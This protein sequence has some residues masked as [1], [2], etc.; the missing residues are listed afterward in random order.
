MSI[1]KTKTPSMNQKIL[2]IIPIIAIL[3]ILVIVLLPQTTD[4]VSAQLVIDYGT[5][6]IQHNNGAWE[7]ATSG[8][9]L[10]QSDTI[11]T[12]ENTYASIILFESSII[13]LDSNTQVFIKELIQ[14]A[15]ATNVTIEQETGRTW[16]TIQKI[17]GID[18]YEVQTPTT[19]ASV[20]GTTFDVNVTGQG[21][22]NVSVIRGNVNVS[23][24]ENGTIIISIP[25]KGNESIVVDP[26]SSKPLKKD[27]VTK[28]EWIRRNLGEDD[29]LYQQ[30]KSEL[31]D[32]LEEYIPDLKDRYGMS[33]EELEILIDG[34]LQGEIDLPPDT[35][36]WIRD[37]I[38]NP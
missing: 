20:R 1:K 28:D 23:K 10:Y 34:Y 25:V 21:V 4:S 7:P 16:N 31:Y 26:K 29:V 19:V 11:R 37:I 14:E 8:I 12:G 15:A 18:N 17:S 22:T 6:E 35:P 24:L 9:L 38:E 32:R 27:P 2:I 5:V 3:I 30:I 33:D 13:R 36:D